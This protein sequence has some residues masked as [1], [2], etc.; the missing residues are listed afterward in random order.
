MAG[1]TQPP[2]PKAKVP[3]TGM[4]RRLLKPL[5]PAQAQTGKPGQP[6]GGTPEVKELK[7]ESRKLKVEGQM[8]KKEN[9]EEV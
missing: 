8:S 6:A 9:K 5:S 2:K 4:K 3:G 7:V 1:E